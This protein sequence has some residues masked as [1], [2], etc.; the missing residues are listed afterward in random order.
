MDIGLID[1]EAE[2]GVLF[3]KVRELYYLRS[4]IW[5]L[6]IMD[7]KGLEITG[8]NPARSL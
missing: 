2:T 4:I 8:D 3:F 1:Q 5:V 6:H 7:F